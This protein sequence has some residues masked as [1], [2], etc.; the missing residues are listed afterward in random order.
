[1]RREAAATTHH[2]YHPPITPSPPSIA[3][4]SHQKH[5]ISPI[6]DT[7]PQPAPITLPEHVPGHFL[8]SLTH[9]V[10][11]EYNA[12]EQYAAA[13]GILNPSQQQRAVQ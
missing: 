12:S 6:D 5:A 10:A 7:R 3:I 1:M 13:A 11:A 8:Q 4:V 2:Q 9:T